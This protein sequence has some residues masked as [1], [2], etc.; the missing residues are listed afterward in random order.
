M[1]AVV[2]VV[3]SPTEPSTQVAST[4]LRERAAPP[5][6][7]L[8]RWGKWASLAAA[9]GCVVF[10]LVQMRPD[11]LVTDTTPSGGD[12]GAHVW[13]PA[14]MRDHL[15]TQGRI[16]GWTPDWY[17]GFPAYHYYMIVPP[18]AIIAVNAGIHW[19][20]GIPV[21]VGLMVAAW[22]G[23]KHPAI[24]N[25]GMGGAVIGL[26]AVV[27]VS[28]VA[29]PYGSAF[30]VVSVA[31]VV[32][33]PLAGWAMARLATAREPIPALVAVGVTV[34][35][36]DTNF[37]IY[38]GNIASTL[39]GEFA[40]SISLA[41]SLL[42]IG[43][44]MR[45][46]DTGRW[47][48]SGAVLLALV[49]L[50][51][52]IPLI[53]V[54]F[55]CLVLVAFAPTMPRWWAL[56]IL[57]GAALIPI[58]LNE[59]YG[60]SRRLAALGT[61][62]IVLI[63]LAALSPQLVQRVRTLAIVGPVGALISG[64]WLFPFYMRSDYF[65]DMGWERLDDYYPALFTTPMKL[66]L[67]V[68][69][70]GAI[71]AFAFRDRL[72]MLF[73]ILSIATAL[74]V[75]NVPDG[76]LWNAR[77]LPFFYLSVYILAAIAIAL[78]ARVI[79][80]AV[81]ERIEAPDFPTTIGV[82]AVALAASLLGISFTLQNV[83]F[84]DQNDSGQY[85]V[86]GL[87]GGDRSFIPSWVTWN[88]S[89]YEEKRSYGEY[90]SVV[91]TMTTVGEE[92][93]C[94]RAMWEY[95]S[96]LDRYGTPMALMLL[97]HWT[98]GCI[99]SMEGLYFESSATTPF[100]FLN[101]S[102]L[103]VGP[104]RAQRDLPYKDF[105]INKGIAQLQTT[106]VRYYM[107]QSDD[108]IAAAREHPDLTEV[109]ESQPFIVF[110]VANALIVEALAYEPVVATGPT[111]DAITEISGRFDVG[112]ESQAVTFYNDPDTFQALPAETGPDEWNEVTT[113]IASDGRPLDPIE[114]TDIAVGRS[115]I[116]FSVDQVG[117]P[118]LVK[119]SYF[120]NWSVSG[121]EGPYRAGPNLMVVIPTSNDVRLSY[122]NTWV[123][124]VSFLLFGLG[125]GGAAL[126]AFD[127]ARNRRRPRLAPEVAR[128]STVA[129]PINS[130]PLQENGWTP[131][132][133]GSRA[134]SIPAGEEDDDEFDERLETDL[135]ARLLAENEQTTVRSA[136]SGEPD[137]NLQVQIADRML[138]AMEGDAASNSME[139]PWKERK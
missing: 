81:S 93:G 119:M 77:V 38:G 12:M 31:G 127:G 82:V 133:S 116:S 39:A 83:P 129:P 113:I 41:L 79:G 42:T 137:P 37:N 46:L 8:E 61:L 53:F 36:F 33:M 71:L 104:S 68:A 99:G 13:G 58:G 91:E 21:A 122:G 56:A 78:L 126:L 130:A 2:E 97:P 92:V 6:D 60:T 75:A 30:K 57:V 108:A 22:I 80:T 86:F 24:R 11:L 34:F 128:R 69:A 85:A 32:L 95:S 106:G 73:T 17:A 16:T 120:P 138:G 139:L 23:S 52:V 9:L 101:Q 98:D 87:E 66:A 51:H 103:S 124:Y 112:W 72:G 135:F 118:V 132:P 64:I 59:G 44:L 74:G 28:L 45:T 25:R 27:A 18:L 89:G 48:A 70:V 54:M 19:L 10:V 67:P 131:A 15:L 76:K 88:Y 117:V 115:S 94:G 109:A 35:L 47:R 26:G 123:E 84:G 63:A 107:A 3:G 90:A 114:V 40:F 1:P 110:E 50:T 121:A 55:V 14:Y 29:V 5:T 96:D 100:H 136:P 49:A 134:A 62:P 65:N 4:P 7:L 20:L 111:D 43:W 105:D 125:V 102:M